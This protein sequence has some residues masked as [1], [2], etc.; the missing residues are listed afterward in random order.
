MKY[1]IR[2]FLNNIPRKYLQLF[3]HFATW[4]LSVFYLGNRVECN[5]CHRH[6]RRFLPYGYV[7]PRKNALCPHCLS[8]ERHRLM[9][10]YL[11]ERTSFYT[12]APRVL[13]VAPELC[14]IKRFEAL[15]GDRYTT[16]DLESPLA[17]VKMDVQAI[18][19]PDNTFDVVFCNHILEHVESD[20]TALRE[21]CRVL[22]PGGWGIVQ[23]PVNR[24][25][26]VTYEDPTIVTP[27][28]R[29]RHFGQHDHLREF[30]ADYA[31]RLARGGFDVVEDDY[32]RALSPETVRRHALPANEI[33]Y[34]VRKPTHDAL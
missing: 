4:L 10:L 16:A 11:H 24:G 31:Q 9:Q 6:Y 20:L 13:H 15:L 23:S 18:P 21:L 27:E 28:E 22:K 2:W 8:L 1:A 12:A 29:T 7:K 34:L 14:F 32:V 17:K 26:T 33:I 30:G 19:F 3:A 25:R 5:I